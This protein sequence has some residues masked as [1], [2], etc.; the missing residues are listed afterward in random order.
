MKQ[1]YTKWR[2]MLEE[3][4]LDAVC[5]ATPHDLHY[6]QTMA[7]LERGLHVLVDK[8][9]ALTS[10]QAWDVVRTAQAA[11]RVVTHVVGPRLNGNWRSAKKA[12]QEGAIGKLRQIGVTTFSY[13]RF[14]WQEPSQEEQERID[15]LFLPAFA[16]MGVPEALYPDVRNPEDWRRHPER[17][18]GGV[19]ANNGLHSLDLGLWLGGSPPAEVFAFAETAGLGVEVCVTAQARLANGVLVSVVSADIPANP[20]IPKFLIGDEGAIAPGEKGA[21]VLTLPSGTTKLDPEE[22]ITIETAFVN[23]VLDGAP[24]PSPARDGAID[25]AFLEAM[26]TSIRECRVVTANVPQ[27]YA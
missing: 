26:Y 11:N 24:D 5:I 25:V 12:I 3:A 2:E 10:A 14:Q 21:M 27:E 16:R 23:A 4:D 8:P 9:I 7:A 20:A 22:T 1:G 19:I 17:I 18:G 15:G 13:R 6:E